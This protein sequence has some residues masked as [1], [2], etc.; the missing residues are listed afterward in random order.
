MKYIGYIF[1]GFFV[2]WIVE[3]LSINVGTAIGAGPGEIGL[4]VSAISILCAIVVI[5]TLI[6]VDTIKSNNHNE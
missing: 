5:C 4:A 3:F 1:I 6:I 2:F